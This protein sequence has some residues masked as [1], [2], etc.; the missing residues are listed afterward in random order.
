MSK[1]LG[2]KI[3]IRFT[4]KLVGD[5]SGKNPPSVRGKNYFRPTG[6]ATAS[7][8]YSSYAASRAFDGDTSSYWYTRE[9]GTQSLL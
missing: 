1:G 4:E 6:T 7:S 5:V 3:A 2:Q 9:T 8:Q